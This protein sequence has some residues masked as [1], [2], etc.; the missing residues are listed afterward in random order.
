MKTSLLL[1]AQFEKPVVPLEQICK[2]YFSCSRH[3][4]FVKA[5]AG[6]LPVP[7]FRCGSN[8]G[9]WMI[10]ISDLAV[11]IDSQREQARKDWV[12]AN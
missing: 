3:T 10:H 11:M 2:E 4:A 8:K 9:T 12:G 5:K 1:M 7:A 6:T